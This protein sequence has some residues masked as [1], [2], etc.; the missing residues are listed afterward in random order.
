MNET[1]KQP[2][3]VE[4]TAEAPFAATKGSEMQRLHE[5]NVRMTRWAIHNDGRM[6][7]RCGKWLDPLEACG[8]SS[9]PNAGTQRPGTPDGSLATETRKPGSLK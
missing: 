7:Q 6:C 4:R 8:C 1:T 9:S 2:E 3:N 5:I